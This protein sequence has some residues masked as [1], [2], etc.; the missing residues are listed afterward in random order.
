VSELAEQTPPLNDALDALVQA[1]EVFL[2]RLDWFWALL[3]LLSELESSARS[4]AEEPG[5]SEYR[6]ALA[7]L[8]SALTDVVQA[9]LNLAVEGSTP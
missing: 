9:R 3:A 2:D 7:G 5:E 6:D 1:S 8:W 4:L